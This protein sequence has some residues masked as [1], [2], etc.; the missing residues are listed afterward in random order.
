M[1]D[2]PYTVI[3]GRMGAAPKPS[4]APTAVPTPQAVTPVEQAT[5]AAPEPPN[6]YSAIVR[7]LT[8]PPPAK[9]VLDSAGRTDADKFAQARKLGIEFGIPA[10]V[11]ERNLEEIQARKKV[12]DGDAALESAPATKGWLQ[13]DPENAKL[14]HDQISTMAGF[15]DVVRQMADADASGPGT[16]TAVDVARS[17]P[18]GAVKG[19]GSIAGLA[20]AGASVRGLRDRALAGVA[21]AAGLETLAKM[22]ED[23][24]LRELRE[25]E[26]KAVEGVG[27][28]V[29]GFGESIGPTNKNF[30]TDVGEGVGQVGMQITA[31]LMTGGLGG[32]AILFGQGADQVAA[33][34]KKA[35]AEGTA[36]GDLGILAGGAT[37]ALIEKYGLG[38][39][40]KKLPENVQSK[41][42]RVLLG[43]GT[44]GATEILE[45][46]ANNVT[47][48][49]LYD[50]ERVLFGD[51]TLYQGG[52][53]AAVGAL[54]SAAIP[55]R[56]AIKRREHLTKVIED[57]QGSPL[58]QR[59][60]DKAI[61]HAAAVLDTNNVDIYVSG[62]RLAEEA[63]PERLT[64]LGLDRSVEQAIERGGDVRLTNEQF[65]KL[66]QEG[67]AGNLVDDVRVGEGAMTAAE[68]KT[69]PDEEAQKRANERDAE[70]MAEAEKAAPAAPAEGAEWKANQWQRRQLIAAGFGKEEIEGM[71][72]QD[73]LDLVGEKPPS[74]DRWHAEAHEPV[75]LAEDQ[76]GLKAMF[77]TAEEAG[78]TDQQYASYLAALEEAGDG[79]RKRATERAIKRQQKQ[80]TT[81]WQAEREVVRQQT[82]E[83]VRQLPIYSALDGLNVDRLDAGAIVEIMGQESILEILPKSNGRQIFQRKGGIHPDIYAE[84]YGFE[85]GRTMIDEMMAALP[86]K[87]KI[88]AETDRKM[89]E[90][91]GAILNKQRDL[92][93]ALEDLH[94]D[95][96]YLKVLTSELKALQG[97]TKKGGALDPALFR[98]TASAGL[99]QQQIRDINPKL[100]LDEE[101]RKG[102]L[103]GKL[104]RGKG[105]VGGEKLGGTNR[106]A[107]A[108]AKFEQILNFE[109]AR[110]A[111][112]VRRQVETQ[113]KHLAD[114]ADPSKAI[115]G[116]DAGHRD[117]LIELL[118]GYDFSKGFVRA[119]AG[120]RE[121]VH[122]GN[123][124]LGAFASLHRQAKVIETEGRKWRSLVI[125]GKTMDFEEAKAQLIERLSTLPE[126]P[127]MKREAAGDKTLF[128][129]ARSVLA[130]AQAALS[131]V[132]LV[133]KKLDGGELAG[134]WHKA[135]FQPLVDAQTMKL[136]LYQEALTPIIEGAKGLPEAVGKK[137]DF[138]IPNVSLGGRKVSYAEALMVALNSGNA[139]NSEKMIEGSQ[140]IPDHQKWTPEEVQAALDALPPEAAAW[141][142]GVF[143]RFEKIRPMVEGVYRGVH[144]ISPARIE[145]RKFKVGGVEV[146]GGY[147]PLAYDQ[148]ATAPLKESS[149]EALN[150][151]LHPG[152]RAGVFS[153]MT[154][155]REE[156]YAAPV[157]LEFSGLAHA[158]ERHLHFVSHFEAFNNTRKLLEDRSISAALTARVGPEYRDELHRWLDAVA[159]N[160]ADFKTS[161]GANRVT[162]FIRTNITVA[163][164][165][166]SYSTLASQTLGLST[167]IAV[168]GAGPGG[169]F[170]AR[171]GGKWMAVGLDRYAADM[172]GS[173][174]MAKELS[175]EM[176]HRLGNADREQAE[177]LRQTAEG[178]NVYMLAQRASLKTIGGMQFYTIDMPT[179]IGAFNQG[180][181]RDMSERDAAN[182]ADAAVRT[183]Q[184]SGHLKDQAALQRQKGLTQFLTMFSTFTTLLY[185]LVSETVGS[186]VANP[187]RLPSTISRLTFLLVVAAAGEALIRQ[188]FPDEDEDDAAKL[189][190][191][192]LKSLVL[193]I[194]STPVVGQMVAGEIEGFKGA[195]M[196][197]VQGIPRKTAE[198]LKAMA[199]IVEEQDVEL[200]DARK[201]LDAVGL[202]VGLPGTAQIV[203]VLKA[204]EEESDNP[205]DYLVTPKKN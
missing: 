89:A 33:D 130:S 77:A 183:S 109:Y 72:Q 149:S 10:E 75:A 204:I 21:R 147:F 3:V 159:T 49:A 53:G 103:A 46:V 52:V 181:S 161:Q 118:S 101:A 174:E 113:R 203:R 158:I 105:K 150:M 100:F 162:Q 132:E 199:K 76:L 16:V 139:S 78:M 17:V 97:E 168:L 54:V 8:E 91:H 156:S 135:V 177:A 144:G 63:G 197:P 201:V 148:R 79:A 13:S 1:S 67:V 41:I 74:P 2:N 133:V 51:D 40:M 69:V 198:A 112:D 185:G 155:A 188:D 137:L 32:G 146:K 164:L 123:M 31:L 18:A 35:G 117:R 176:R 131:K 108:K 99:A 134:P 11:V 200:K 167:S 27:A 194:K 94:E 56:R 81:E 57:V 170:S 19:V 104:I 102:K 98:A 12:L 182:Y 88:E 85:D 172:R 169:K 59:A 138:K 116:I 30:L 145:S 184:G 36:G 26:T 128:D 58:A 6:P 14:S 154:K 37:T 28:A 121:T 87:E 195:Q 66:A 143:D 157:S 82:E 47:A 42:F 48:L 202:A 64:E 92:Q 4:P 129:R 141:V 166:L 191:W 29:K 73:V 196:S 192:G 83:S 55:G 193:G 45:D 44:E 70:A 22:L 111:F 178:R 115:P 96:E 180:L 95:K 34:V 163:V 140:Y 142:Q 68:A 107:A 187:K 65:A 136:D 25:Q 24:K 20:T 39:L 190:K 90:Q 173:V 125:N 160:N 5:P 152:D 61:E 175:G 50:H 23:P 110:Q 60:P 120:L 84:M 179:W 153:G 124:S 93:E 86:I 114:L 106:S 122:Y 43:A 126:L 80:I 71:S 205:Y 15:E 119:P 165:G 38:V 189:A 171:E 151:M 9:L 186:A 7:G 62:V 127:R